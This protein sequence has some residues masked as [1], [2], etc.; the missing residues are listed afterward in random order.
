MF[1][2]HAGECVFLYEEIF[3]RRCY[4]GNGLRLDQNAPG[5]IFDVGAN[6]GM[7]TYF[8]HK[9]YPGKKI[10]AFEPNP[11]AFEV[12]SANV[13]RLGIE[14]T[15][16]SCALSDSP[17][18]AKLTHYPNK[19]CMSGLYADPEADAR[20][21]RAYM[22]NE[23]MDPEDADFLLSETFAPEQYDCTL[24]TVSSIIDR[25]RIE[26]IDLLKIDVEKAELDVLRGIR[27]EHWPLIRQAVIEVHDFGGRLASIRGLLETHGFHSTV[28]Q[29]PKLK[30]TGLYDLIAVRPDEET[31][32]SRA[33]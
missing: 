28:K 2:L 7:A 22:I 31:R 4:A 32:G 30:G 15:V 18:T 26:S 10:F 6:I 16:L 17:G 5:C 11:R 21:T 8:F 3:E 14:A 29:D 23:G 33:R 13:A 20:T 9:E 19:S 27:S 24:T 1:H 12:L 25:D